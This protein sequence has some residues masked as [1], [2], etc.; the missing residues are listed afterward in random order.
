MSS[1][2]VTVANRWRFFSCFED[3]TSL[4]RYWLQRLQLVKTSWRVIL[5]LRAR[6]ATRPTRR[7]RRSAPLPFPD[8][9]YMRLGPQQHFHRSSSIRYLGCMYLWM[10]LNRLFSEA[11]CVSLWLLRHRLETRMAGLYGMHKVC[12]CTGGPTT[13]EAPSQGKRENCYWAKVYELKQRR[14]QKQFL[15]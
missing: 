11:S 8:V 10:L 2:I 1:A 9:G 5:N 12:M 15:Q 3:Y 7:G 6:R 14:L 13:L 4:P